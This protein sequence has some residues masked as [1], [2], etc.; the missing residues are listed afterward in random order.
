MARALAATGGAVI[1]SGSM[2]RGLPLVVALVGALLALTPL[3]FASPPDPSWIGGFYDNADYDDVVLAV[4]SAAGAL[5]ATPPPLLAP[6]AAVIGV[7]LPPGP[8]RAPIAS[9]SALQIRAPPLP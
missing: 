2:R 6:L 7:V 5:D 8:P 1:P 3:A 4:T 9:P